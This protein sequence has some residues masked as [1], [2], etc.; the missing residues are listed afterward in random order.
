[1]PIETARLEHGLYL[2]RW[3]GAVTL[4]EITQAARDGGALMQT[5]GEKQAVLVNDLANAER[6][7]ADVRALRRVA[8]DNPHV[9]ALLVVNAPSMLRMVAEAQ[10][11]SVPWVVGFF[12]TVEAACAHGRALLAGADVQ[13]E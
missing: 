6:L 8:A 10:A 13:T 11:A 2:N 12:E 9:I 4:D 1:M 3:L 5:H 7:P